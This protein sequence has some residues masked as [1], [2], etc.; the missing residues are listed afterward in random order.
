MNKRAGVIYL[1]DRMNDKSAC[2][3]VAQPGRRLVGV[4]YQP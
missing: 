1:A 3:Y 4:E 2:S